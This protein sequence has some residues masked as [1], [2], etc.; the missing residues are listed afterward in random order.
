M[1]YNG[2]HAKSEKVG[3]CISD[4]SGWDVV[5]IRYTCSQQMSPVITFDIAVVVQKV[6]VLCCSRG[7]VC[8]EKV[9]GGGSV[10]GRDG[11]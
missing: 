3:G 2:R 6:K 8:S 9:G 5:P 10:M 4:R 11:Y 1:L 7:P